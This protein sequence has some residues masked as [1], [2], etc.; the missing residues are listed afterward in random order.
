[1]ETRPLFVGI[2][3]S[4]GQL[5]VAQ[6]PAGTGQVFPHTECGIE[7]LVAQMRA[8]KPRLLC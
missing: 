7:N 3:V 8:L 1:M 5:D 6:Q 2:D 4:K